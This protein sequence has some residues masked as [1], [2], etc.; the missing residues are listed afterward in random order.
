MNSYRW[1]A[2][3]GRSLL[4]AIIQC[5]SF[6]LGILVMLSTISSSI[7]PPFTGECYTVLRRDYPDMY[8]GIIYNMIIK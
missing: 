7:K 6:V 3:C 5:V 1:G 8:I 2:C 4:F